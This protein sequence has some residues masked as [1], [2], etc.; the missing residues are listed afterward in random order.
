[1]KKLVSCGEL[2]KGDTFVCEECGLELKVSKACDCG[3]EGACT[4]QGFVCC[5]DSMKKK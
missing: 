5:G 1:M 4:E 3:E 2:K